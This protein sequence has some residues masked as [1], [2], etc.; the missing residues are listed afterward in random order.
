ML[1]LFDVVV[2]AE[3]LAL[4]FVVWLLIVPAMASAVSWSE[5]LLSVVRPANL[6]KV[7]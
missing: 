2:W 5:T 6:L 4:R 1:A 3:M 7:A